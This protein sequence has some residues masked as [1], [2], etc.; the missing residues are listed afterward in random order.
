MIFKTFVVVGAVLTLI[1]AQLPLTA[2]QALAADEI[3]YYHEESTGPCFFGL[4]NCTTYRSG[5]VRTYSSDTTN[6]SLDTN[7]SSSSG[8]GIIRILGSIVLFIN[9]VLLPFLFAL[10]FL[11]FLINAFRFFILTGGSSEGHEKAGRLALYGIL[12][13]VLMV[14][15]WG[16]VNMLVNGF[17][18]DRDDSIVPDYIEENRNP[19]GETNNRSS[20]K[21]NTENT[22][23]GGY[24][25]GNAPGGAWGQ[26]GGAGGN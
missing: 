9:Y 5:G 12:A 22:Y 23:R 2:A 6:D 13:F 21:N 25:T 10:A 8:G 11:F 14:S 19:W 20:N 3:E 24:G 18:I 16:I 15:V 26:G 4:F 1:F 17:G 7:Y